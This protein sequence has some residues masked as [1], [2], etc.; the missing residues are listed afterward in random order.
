M[1]SL[2][3]W[4]PRSFNHDQILWANTGKVIY[5][6]HEDA[7]KSRPNRARQNRHNVGAEVQKMVTFTGFVGIE[8]DSS[9]IATL[10]GH[11]VIA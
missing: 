4:F 5:I 1:C 6:G 10:Q 11:V 7:I 2:T 9:D 8:R 3:R